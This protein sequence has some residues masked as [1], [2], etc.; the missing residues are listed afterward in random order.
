MQTRPSSLG[1]ASA[2]HYFWRLEEDELSVFKAVRQIFINRLEQTPPYEPLITAYDSQTILDTLWSD[3][4]KEDGFPLTPGRASVLE[5]CAQQRVTQLLAAFASGVTARDEFARWTDIFIG[6]LQ[7]YFQERPQAP[8][9]EL[10]QFLDSADHQQ[11]IR[12]AYFRPHPERYAQMWRQQADSYLDAD[13]IRRLT[14]RG[15]EASLG[16]DLRDLTSYAALVRPLFAAACEREVA[17]FQ[18]F[19]AA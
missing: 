10:D 19:C 12:Y 14:M 18:Q 5:R 8:T 1:Q 11:A 4:M 15:W 13:F 6:Q 17:H 2:K 9:F 3:G 7:I 16:F